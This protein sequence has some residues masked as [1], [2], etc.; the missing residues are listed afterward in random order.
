M[1]DGTDIPPM[2]WLF[3]RSERRR[4]AVQYWLRDTAK[5]LLLTAQFEGL[6]VL[7]IDACSA[8]GA[9]MAKNASRRY[10]GTRCPR[11]R[12]LEEA[13]PRAI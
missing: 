12:K 9:M 1:A 3:E 10:A 13:S 4:R 7:P 6:K 11:P 5:G 2:R 8:F